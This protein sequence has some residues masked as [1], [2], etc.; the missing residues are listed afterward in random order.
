M[1][2]KYEAIPEINFHWLKFHQNIHVERRLFCDA[3][4][5]LQRTVS[6][7]KALKP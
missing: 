6:D 4:L 1:P 3:I 5:L 7:E 2:D